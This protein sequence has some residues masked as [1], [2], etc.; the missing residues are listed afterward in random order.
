VGHQPPIHVAAR[1]TYDGPFVVGHELMTFV[2]AYAVSIGHVKPEL[3]AHA[4]PSGFRSSEPGEDEDG[5]ASRLLVEVRFYAQSP[6]YDV[7]GAADA[8][9]SR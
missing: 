7:G 1:K 5:Y 3:P 9:R 2:L 8:D 6:D 4:R